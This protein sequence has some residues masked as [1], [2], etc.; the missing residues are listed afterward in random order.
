[1]NLIKLFL[2]ISFLFVG[3]LAKQEIIIDGT[4]LVFPPFITA[5]TKIEEI[6]ASPRLFEA[7]VWDRINNKLYF[8]GYEKGKE[9]L[10]KFISIGK[11]EDVPLSQ[12]TGGTIIGPDPKFLYTANGETH[13]IIKFKLYGDEWKHPEVLAKDNSWFQPNDLCQTINGDI[14]FTDPDFKNKKDGAVYHL[15]KSG[16]VT[17]VIS[18]L[19]VPNGIISS[20]DGKKIYVSD[21]FLKEWRVYQVGKDGMLDKGTLFFKPSA[22]S[23]NN[24]D[25]M[26]IDVK[27]NIYCTG[28]GGICIVT[29]KGK[30]IGF[31]PV[32]EVCTNIAFG[33]NEYTTLY[34]SCY[35][36]VYS[37]KTNIKGFVPSK[38]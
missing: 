4:K 19:P 16:K 10:M 29:P 15:S 1:M 31:I 32:P 2:L 30:A 5:E 9:M 22:V 27:G 3:C 25:G 26:T 33:G 11:A 38:K 36:K 35:K 13:E 14:Y 6:Y 18:D 24:P 20:N 8:T 7:P 34:I 21:S 28:L 23:K 37:F 17:K 12:G